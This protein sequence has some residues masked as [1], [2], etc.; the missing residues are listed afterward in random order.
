LLRGQGLQP[1]V[2]ERLARRVKTALTNMLQDQEGRWVLSQHVQASNEFALTAWSDTRRNVRLD[3]I[4]HGGSKP[5]ESGVDYLWIIDYKTA[6]HGRERVDEFLAEERTK[7]TDQMK[8]YARMMKDHVA[9]GRLRVG[10][11]YPMLPKLIWW[12]PETD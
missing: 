9:S 12:N 4:F 8:V 11:Y 3:R 5:M 1:V 2:I 6:A 7:Y 10:L